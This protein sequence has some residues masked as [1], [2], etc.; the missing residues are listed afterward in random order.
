MNSMQSLEWTELGAA[1]PG[2]PRLL[3]TGICYEHLT[4]GVTSVP[5]KRRGR[6]S[7][8]SS[9]VCGKARE[10]RLWVVVT[11]LKYLKGL[12]LGALGSNKN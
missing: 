4:S 5:T 7:A 11:L 3:E 8:S 1:W 2:Q 9:H 10:G 6:C 12:D